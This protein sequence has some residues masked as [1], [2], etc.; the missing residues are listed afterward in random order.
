MTH[1]T[2]TTHSSTSG[3][4]TQLSQRIAD[5]DQLELKSGEYTEYKSL[6]IENDIDPDNNFFSNIIDNC[7]YYTQEQYNQSIKAEGKLSIIHF[8]CRSMY[9]N[10]SKIKKYLQQ[11][12]NQFNIITLSET[13]INMENGVDFEMEGYEFNYI[14]RNNKGGGGVAVYVDSNLNYT[15]VESMTTVIDNLV[16][17][18]TIEICME[19]SRNVLIS[20]IYRAPDTNMEAFKD[21]IEGMY[22]LSNQ[23]VLFICGDTNIDLLKANQ[24]RMTEEF[25]NTMYS[26]S[27]HPNITRPSRI[28]VHSATLIDNI[29]TNDI[30]NKTISGLLVNDISDHLPVFSVY[31]CNC[32][33]NKTDCKPQYRRVRTEEAMNAL[34]YDLLTYDWGSLYMEKDIDGAYDIFL[35]IFKTLYDKNCP[36]K[37][38][39]RKHNYREQPWIT[40]GLQNACKKKNTLYREFIKHRTNETE[41]KYKKYKNKLTN[42]IRKCRKEHYSKLLENNK[43]NIKGV[44]KILNSIIKNNSG[45][46][47]YPQYFVDKD[48]KNY[49]MEDV[50]NS[51][52]NFFVNVGPNLAKDIPDP[53]ASEEN[54]A[55]IIK[56]NSCS[57]F[58]SAVDEREVIEVVNKCNNKMSTDCNDIDMKLVK[59]VIGG[60]SKPLTY[61]CNLSFQTGTFPS[62]MKIAKVIPL[63]KSGDKHNFTNYRPVSLLP[64]FS[65]ILE[66]LFNNRLDTFIEKH[67]LLSDSQ[68]GFRANRSTSMA[69]MESV[70][71]ITNAIVD[72]KYVAGIFIDLKKAFDTINHEILI[73]KLERYGIRGIV[74]NWLRSYLSDRKQFVKLDESESSCLNIACGV[75]QGS[76]LGPK[77]FILYIND[78]CDVSK[79]LKMVVFADDTNIFCSG[80]DLQELVDLVSHELCKLKSWFD[81]NKLS[82]NLSKTKFMIF[83]NLKID[84]EV[85][86]K[87]DGI[88]IERV[89]ENKFLGVIIDDKINWKSHIKYIHSKLARS[90]SVLSKARHVL[91]YK[92]LRMLY[93]SLVLPYLNYCSEVWGNT[94]KSSLHAITILQKRAIRII[95]NVGYRD[96]TNSLFL[97][98]NLLKFMDIIEYKTAIIMYKARN[99]QLPANIQVLFS[100]REGGYNLRGEL[101]LK[102]AFARIKVKSFCISVC[103]VQLWNN[104]NVEIMQC[105]NMIQFKKRYKQNI[106]MRYK[107]D[108]SH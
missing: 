39:S 80:T 104:M 100:D 40:K 54:N 64:Q 19:M 72:Y 55:H 77:L 20:C 5:Y 95:H 42:I 69:L 41:T 58:L 53:V 8:N 23:K 74:L 12:T 47:N 102:T 33:K 3:G 81:R 75:P 25:I 96:H 106:I 13:W 92:S 98:S 7:Y 57:M 34:K 30:D 90:I 2:N 59:S 24:H 99:K 101:K 22:T 45:H 105:S 36:L 86:I 18:L 83:S 73:N 87:V 50:V 85:S 51:F 52:N 28:T 84:S 21:W 15:M 37:Q 89:F 43:N 93:C 9:A 71:E 29:F 14:N 56:R 62:N 35:K 6:D 88:E 11:F 27:L 32:K 78:M 48:I 61:I 38:Y 4:V 17:C 76:V 46:K 26:M 70:E 16:E 1:Y 91:D 107:E 82:L 103:G 67:S 63:F 79:I 97:N 108:E 49:N 31:D 66:K 65:K 94:Y 68:Y 60:I 10:F 44:W